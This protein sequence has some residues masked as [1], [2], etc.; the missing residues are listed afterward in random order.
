ML[1]VSIR[2]D[3]FG[4]VTIEVTFKMRIQAALVLPRTKGEKLCCSHRILWGWGFR[5]AQCP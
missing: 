3:E 5:Q 2:A 4:D 1:L